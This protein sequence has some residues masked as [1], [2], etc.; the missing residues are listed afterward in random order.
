MCRTVF[1]LS[2]GEKQRTLSGVR[3]SLSQV[4]ITDMMF[5]CCDGVNECDFS[6]SN[7]TASD[8]I[9]LFAAQVAVT[10]MPGRMF[11]T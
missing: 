10:D 7:N 4:A 6:P 5:V 8:T 2:G 1:G 11:L 3:T 9:E